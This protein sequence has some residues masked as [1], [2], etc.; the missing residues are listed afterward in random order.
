[1]QNSKISNYKIFY[2]LNNNIK[3]KINKNNNTITFQAKKRISEI[4]FFSV[5]RYFELLCD[6]IVFYTA[7]YRRI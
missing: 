3:K 6:F 2:M 4:Y 5:S 7:L 1:M